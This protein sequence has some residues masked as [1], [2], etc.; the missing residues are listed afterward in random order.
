M[1]DL[2]PDGKV[3]TAMKRCADDLSLR[4]GHTLQAK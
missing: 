1:I 2:S 3:V 4:P